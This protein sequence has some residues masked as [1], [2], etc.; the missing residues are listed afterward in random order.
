MTTV[1]GKMFHI[2]VFEDGFMEEMGFSLDNVE[3][4]WF[5]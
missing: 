3:R 5:Q 1:K 4:V 2:W